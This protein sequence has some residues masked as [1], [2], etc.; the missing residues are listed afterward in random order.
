MMKIF[1]G[2]DKKVAVDLGSSRLRIFVQ[3]KGLILDEASA[4]AVDQQKGKV[5]AVGDKAL[6]MKGRVEDPV[7]V[8]QPIQ[9]PKLTDD[10][11]IFALLKAL[12]QKV[13]QDYYFFNPTVVVSVAHQMSPALKEI[14]TEIFANLGA[15]ETIIV[16]QP[17][18]AAIGM[19]VPIAD[20]SGCFLLQLGGGVV[21]A[22]AIAL[23]KVVAVQSSKRAGIDMDQKLAA[24]VARQQHLEIGLNVA[25][26]L[27]NNLA[28][29][30]KDLHYQMVASGQG[31]Q[32]EGPCEIEVFS[33]Q[34]QPLVMD[35]VQHWVQLLKQLLAEVPPDLTTDA[36][37]KGILLAGGLA[38]L[39]N[40][41]QELSTQLSLP[42]SVAEEPDLAVINGLGKLL[43]HL[44]E[45]KQSVGYQLT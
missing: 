6:A 9:Q 18:A 45:F 13:N 40:L 21:E 5:I 22:A 19:G 30:N 42:V 43:D 29:T 34:L 16:S 11:Q 24:L 26:Q 39:H 36:I 23:G 4:L 27:K 12:L 33:D 44:D 41:D 7:K 37:D 2:L 8:Y 35:Y 28:T 32:G 1:S 3:G 17:L 38:Q 10:E 14:V 31:C 20:A 15:K 25:Q